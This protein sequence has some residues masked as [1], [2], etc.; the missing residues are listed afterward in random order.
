MKYLM[1]S[2]KKR[3]LGSNLYPYHTNNHSFIPG[4]NVV[5][6]IS[7]L[8]LTAWKLNFYNI[9]QPLTA[10]PTIPATSCFSIRRNRT[11][12]GIMARNAAAV[13]NSHCVVYLPTKL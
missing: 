4:S 6:S 2:D 3:I 12:I 9:Y 13:R 1:N 11:M 8:C 5:Y 7:S 10:P